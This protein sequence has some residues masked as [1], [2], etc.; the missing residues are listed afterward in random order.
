MRLGQVKNQCKFATFIFILFLTGKGTLRRWGEYKNC[1]I[2]STFQREINHLTTL[3]P[4]ST[5]IFTSMVPVGLPV[6][7]ALQISAYS[8]SQSDQSSF[9][10]LIATIIIADSTSLSWCL[11]PTC[12]STSSPT[13]SGRCSAQTWC[14]LSLVRKYDL[15][16]PM[17]S[18]LHWEFQVEW[19]TPSFCQ[20]A[21]I[22][23]H[24]TSPQ[25][26]LHIFSGEV[27]IV[28]WLLANTIQVFG[29]KW[30]AVLKLFALERFL[31][32]RNTGTHDNFS[33]AAITG[34]I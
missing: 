32:G 14:L 26:I 16:A 23:M 28:F 27:G 13:S 15:F 9:F 1:T 30:W 33:I 24:S 5:W 2:P 11:S 20:G 25:K 3:R 12:A 19:A 6:L 7:A 29:S 31:Q 21:R 10:E 34:I 4:V 17:T 18:S 8:T 22:L